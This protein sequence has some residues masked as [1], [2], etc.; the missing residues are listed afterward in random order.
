MNFWSRLRLWLLVVAF[1]C[2]QLA[3]L[4]HAAEH[5][6]TEAEDSVHVCLLC[7]AGHDLGSP[8]PAMAAVGWPLLA[9]AVAAL[10]AP[11]LLPKHATL[12]SV[13]ARGPPFA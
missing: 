1:A 3:M 12:S 10:P 6:A 11:L 8:V 5:D 9:A 2:G 7:L 4:A 13:L